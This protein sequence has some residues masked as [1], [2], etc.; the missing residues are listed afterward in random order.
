LSCL[1]LA[2]WSLLGSV[3]VEQCPISAKFPQVSIRESIKKHTLKSIFQAVIPSTYFA[4]ASNQA[5]PCPDSLTTSP[6]PKHN[7]FMRRNFL[8]LSATYVGSY[9]VNSPILTGKLDR[10]TFLQNSKRIANPNSCLTQLISMHTGFDPKEI[11]RAQMNFQKDK[12]TCS[13]PLPSSLLDKVFRQKLNDGAWTYL[14]VNSSDSFWMEQY[15]RKCLEDVIHSNAVK[16]VQSIVFPEA[17]ISYS[18][19]NFKHHVCAKRIHKK[20]TMAQ[21]PCSIR[22]M[23]PKDFSSQWRFLDFPL[24]DWEVLGLEHSLI[25]QL[26]FDEY[27]NWS[28]KNAQSLL[29]NSILEDP[30]DLYHLALKIS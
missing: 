26:M 21:I 12:I 13:L 8:L 4:I 1:V 25:A 16:T 24:I 22:A 11:S 14:H 17:Q 6:G 3:W 9:F 7:T 10:K 30:S 23:E 28:L 19:E 15:N 18:S 27:S 20:L 29:K 5:V 2:P